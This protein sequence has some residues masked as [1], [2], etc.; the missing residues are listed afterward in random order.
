MRAPCM[1]RFFVCPDWSV[2]CLF[3]PH[4]V[5]GWLGAAAWDDLSATGRTLLNVAARIV[6]P[7]ARDPTVWKAIQRQLQARFFSKLSLYALRWV[8][9]H[10]CQTQ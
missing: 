3:H 7:T 2:D 1:S 10:L 9:P 6:R 4:D 5:T 8:L